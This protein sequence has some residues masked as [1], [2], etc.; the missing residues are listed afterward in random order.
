[1]RKGGRCLGRSGPPEV[2]YADGRGVERL[3]VHPRARDGPRKGLDGEVGVGTGDD[4]EFILLRFADMAQWAKALGADPADMKLLRRD[5]NLVNT[6]GTADE[7]NVEFGLLYRKWISKMRDELCVAERPAGFDGDIGDGWEVIH[8]HWEFG[9]IDLESSY[10]YLDL[11]ALEDYEP[12]TFT[13]RWG[14]EE[15][16]EDG[17]T[18]TLRNGD[19]VFGPNAANEYCEFVI[20]AE[21]NDY[22]KKL[23]DYVQTLLKLGLLELRD[24]DEGGTFVSVAPW[25]SRMV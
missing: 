9:G 2:V 8:Q 3:V 5:F 22:G 4:D 12:E 17:E 18:I 16:V 19:E 10:P 24:S 14:E 21:L 6:L 13:N 20:G 25:H 11:F 1:M 23:F 15:L 7:R